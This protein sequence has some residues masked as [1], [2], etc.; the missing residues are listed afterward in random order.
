MKSWIIVSMLYRFGWIIYIAS[1]LGLR[2]LCFS[3]LSTAILNNVNMNEITCDILFDDVV[4]L[5]DLID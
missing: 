2:S 5:N 1:K 4:V 3:M